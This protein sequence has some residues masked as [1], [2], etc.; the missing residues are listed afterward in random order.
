MLSGSDV[1][2]PEVETP[3]SGG[4]WVMTIHESDGRIEGVPLYRLGSL[5]LFFTGHLVSVAGKGPGPGEGWPQQ[6]SDAAR[7]LAAVA[8]DGESVLDTLRGSFMLALSDRR[9]RRTVVARDPIGFHPLYCARHS[10]TVLFS[11]SA[12]ELIARP[13]VSGSVDPVVLADHLCHRWSSRPSETYLSSVSRLPPGNRAVFS[14]G[15]MRTERGWDPIPDDR[16]VRWLTEEETEAFPGLFEQAVD[17]CL[18]LGRAG[19]FLSGGL[20]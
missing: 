19:V 3:P 4:H 16:P 1:L 13:G 2:A 7:V 9:T 15:R 14:D 11:S 10:E 20:D 6:R 18:S 17:R 8:R 12:L 5:E